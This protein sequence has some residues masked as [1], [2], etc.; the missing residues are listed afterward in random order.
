MTS[1]LIRWSAWLEFIN[2][3]F[4][5]LL[6]SLWVLKVRLCIVHH[7][8]GYCCSSYTA[9]NRPSG[10]KSKILKIRKT[11]FKK[12]KK[13]FASGAKKVFLP[14]ILVLGKYL[15]TETCF[16]KLRLLKL[17]QSF[18]A[19]FFLLQLKSPKFTRKKVI[20]LQKKKKTK[21]SVYLRPCSNMK[22]VERFSSFISR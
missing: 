5:L 15:A 9:K 22:D 6:N 2:S 4:S 16:L 21:L 11:F 1:G 7:H 3:L 20:N 12:S 18:R 19:S 10:N 14:R 8:A 13:H 17:C